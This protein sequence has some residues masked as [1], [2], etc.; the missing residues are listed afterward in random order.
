[1]KKILQYTA[2][3]LAIAAG[4]W[5]LNNQ[6]VVRDWFTLRNY[7]PP[8]YVVQFADDTKMS[9]YGRRLF[10]VSKPELNEREEFNINCPIPEK[11]LVLGCYTNGR[12][13]VFKVEDER[14]DGVEEITSA[15]EMLH[16]AYSRLSANE[17]RGVDE[18]LNRQLAIITDKRV[19]ELVAQYQLDDP[20]TVNN[21]MHSIFGTEL[22]ELL[23]ELEEHYSQYFENR[24]QLVA[25][26]KSYEKVFIDISKQIENLEQEIAAIKTQIEKEESAIATLQESIQSE[27]GRLENLR[28]S[29]D[30]PG[31]NSGVPA[32]NAL[33]ADYN[34]RVDAYKVLVTTHNKK[35]EQ[36]NQLA[37]AQN[38][39]VHS[40]DS[41]FE[42]I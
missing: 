11:S 22:S 28:E 21:E 20:A 6:Y 30:I 39:L 8:E 10:Y 1:M 27:A 16:A 5:V 29:G 42:K 9:D 15:H 3:V 25:I 32:Y 4:W 17:R 36:R 40:L 23:P 34:F 41:K 12:I 26:S 7:T 14:L 2:L 35:V 37:T 38:E 19:I 31:Y 18:I 33:V 13:F 24:S